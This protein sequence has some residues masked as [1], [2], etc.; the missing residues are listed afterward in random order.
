VVDGWWRR[1][2][3]DANNN[4]KKQQSTSVRQQRRI[5]MMAGERQGAVVELE[6]RLFGGRQRLKRCSRQWQK[7]NN[8]QLSGGR[9][10]G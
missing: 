2:Y 3:N 4:D 10:G 7:Y 6:E 9:G 8:Q 1:G 5:M